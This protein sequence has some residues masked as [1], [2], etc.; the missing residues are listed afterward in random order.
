VDALPGHAEHAGEFDG[1]AAGVVLQ[2]G[3]RAPEQAGVLGFHEL[4]AQ[5]LPLPGSQVEL[6]HDASPRSPNFLPA[7]PVSNFFCGPA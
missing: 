5:A 3:E 6:A 1:G 4:A 7:N 2:D